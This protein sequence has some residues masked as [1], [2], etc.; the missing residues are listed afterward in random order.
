MG[1]KIAVYSILD[2]YLVQLGF[3]H[4]WVGGIL[5]FLL[6][7]RN[8]PIILSLPLSLSLSLAISIPFSLYR[9]KRA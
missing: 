9:S 8:F 3:E 4:L 2:S 1:G 6:N 5:L 7:A